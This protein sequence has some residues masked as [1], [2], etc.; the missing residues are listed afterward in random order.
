[1]RGGKFPDYLHMHDHILILTVSQEANILSA[2]RQGKLREFHPLAQGHTA[3]NCD[4]NLDHPVLS[5]AFLK[6]PDF[7][8]PKVLCLS[9]LGRIYSCEPVSSF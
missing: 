8:D 2:W 1:M 7:I 9:Y 6:P 4:S 3:W 5:T